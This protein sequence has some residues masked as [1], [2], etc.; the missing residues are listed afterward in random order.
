MNEPPDADEIRRVT[1]HFGMKK[2]P[3]RWPFTWFLT[4][5]LILGAVVSLIF[6]AAV[7]WAP[8]TTI[9]G[10]LGADGLI[11]CLYFGFGYW[12]AHDD[13]EKQGRL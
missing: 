3:T 11:L 2:L 13:L 7:W 5:G 1:E 10:R 9:A 6:M 4:L 12:A 8:E